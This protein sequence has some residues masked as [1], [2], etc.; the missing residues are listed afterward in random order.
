MSTLQNVTTVTI[1]PSV[2]QLYFFKKSVIIIVSF[3]GLSK[4]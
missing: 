1:R 4:W 2:K 3:E